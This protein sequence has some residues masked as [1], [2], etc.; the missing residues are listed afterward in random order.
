MQ[1]GPIKR[2]KIA[3]LYGYKNVEIAFPGQVLILIAGNGSGKTTI[4][5]ALHAFLRG[6]FN[7]LRSL[8]FTSIECEFHSTGELVTLHKSQ[9]TSLDPGASELL[10][11]M[12]RMGGL[13]EDQIYD[14]VTSVYEP[15]KGIRPFTTN[16]VVRAI[17]DMS[18]WG[19]D[20]IEEK[21][22]ELHALIGSGITEDI[23]LIR[24][25]VA[26]AIDGIEILYLPTYRRIENPMLSPAGTRRRHRL[27]RTRIGTQHAT[28]IQEQ[29]Q[30][31]YALND[32]EER[33]AELSDEAERISN[34][35]YRS[36]SAT[37]IDEALERPSATGGT[38][39]ELPLPDIDSL[40]RFLSRVSRADATALFEAP[41]RESE[42]SSKRRVEAIKDLYATGRIDH[43][44]LGLLRYFLSRLG[45]VIEKTKVTE[46]ML[47]KF[48]E[49]CNGYL[50][51]SS[52][53]K[54]F[55]YEPNSM[56]VTVVNNFTNKVV[57]MNQLSSG[58]TQ[59]ISLFA[60]LYLYPK[61]NLVLIDEPE[62]SLSLDWQR[63]IIPDMMRSESVEQLLAIT[64][65]PFIFEN[66]YD[67][68]AG[69]MNVSRE[70]KDQL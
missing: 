17:F 46:I 63:K 27:V 21:L 69:T 55:V 60:R 9:I 36:A 44:D 41:S 68:F 1:S 61:R 8:E 52:D 34:W 15:E 3:G 12:A 54:K 45:P 33:L 32:V 29:D 28:R 62:L 64:H 42:E 48:V 50:Q 22:N 31:N 35:E 51:S 10:V 58:E 4:L 57:P 67:P 11:E 38:P 70:K 30:I 26:R 14:F 37:I 39:E 24:D 19:F 6:R 16:L 23:Q 7:R 25:Q 49:A 20:D 59:V 53:E 66:E 13:S 18:P 40:V 5:N 56:R 65:S 2:F 47:Q 43:D